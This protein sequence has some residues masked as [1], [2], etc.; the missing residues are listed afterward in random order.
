MLAM[1]DYVVLQLMPVIQTASE[2]SEPET[3]GSQLFQSPSVPDHILQ[4]VQSP[5][6]TPAQPSYSAASSIQAF[7]IP[8]LDQQVSPQP[9]VILYQAQG[10]TTTH[11]SQAATQQVAQPP[12]V[13]KH[14]QLPKT[15]SQPHGP[16][17]K[18]ANLL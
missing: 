15:P 3:Q 16:K 4:N 12:A 17:A 1:E 13:Y 14:I 7:Q 11:F 8:P 10:S 2:S 18:K 6:N 5:Q 9:S